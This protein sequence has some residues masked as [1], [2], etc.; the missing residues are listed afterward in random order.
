VG[1][2]VH[3][4]EDDHG[5]SGL[6]V[7]TWNVLCAFLYTSEFI[8][9]NPMPLVGRPNLARTLPKS[10]P[11]A[12]VIALLAAL[13][14]DPEPRRRSD[15]V[16]RDH[17]LIL[18]ALLA[19]LRADELLRPNVSD[20]HRTDGGA[21]IQIRGKFNKDR[22][23]P[24]ET[25][26]VDVLEGYLDSRAARFPEMTRRR[27][28]PAGGL[29]AWPSTAP[30]FVGAD[31]Q[32]ITRGTLQYRVLRAFRRAGIDADRARG[33]LVYGLRHTFATQLA[34]SNVSVYT[35][36]NILGHESMATSQ[37]YVSAAGT[38]TRSATSQNPLYRFVK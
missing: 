18:T 19:G 1:V 32:R 27:S 11:T 31:G 2:V 14:A 28:S 30:L 26:L 34:N 33:A 17:A 37:R 12:T 8:A 4:V 21:V 13:D 38:E 25:A 15:W 5:A 35:L 29:A 23:V 36:M 9:A 20:V 7:E 16:E 6:V 24:V 3:V 10:L 22:R